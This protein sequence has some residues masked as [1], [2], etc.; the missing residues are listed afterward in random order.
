[1][2]LGEKSYRKDLAFRKRVLDDDPIALQL[3]S[4][5]LPIFAL[6]AN[7]KDAVIHVA[8]T[9]ETLSNIFKAIKWYHDLEMTEKKRRASFTSMKTTSRTW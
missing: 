9:K 7:R 4:H 8:I 2:G 5:H 6:S 1:V 3:V